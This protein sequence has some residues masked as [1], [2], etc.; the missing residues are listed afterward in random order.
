MIQLI[1]LSEW[2]VWSAMVDFNK[3][4]YSNQTSMLNIKAV[5]S[6]IG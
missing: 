4:N 5:G 2:G 1:K 3:K 6:T